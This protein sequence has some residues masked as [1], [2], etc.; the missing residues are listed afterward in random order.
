M[1]RP[2]QRL[3]RILACAAVPV[4][5][6]AAGC[7]SDSDD[8]ASA[9]KSGKQSP[10]PSAS[11]GAKSG[12]ATVKEE[13]TPEAKFAKLPEACKALSKKTVEDLVPAAKDK[14]GT[15]GASDEVSTRGTCSW[16]GLKSNGVDGSQYRWL[17]VSLVRFDS[18]P[19]LGT[20]E[21]RATSYQEKQLRS[22]Q[23][24]EGATGL[25][26]SSVAGV[27]DS[28]T[29]VRYDL[30]KKEG[31]FKQQTVLARTANAVI[32]V[33]Y[34]GAGLAGDKAPD[35][36]KL[37]KDAENAAKEVAASIAAANG[38]GSGSTGSG[39]GSAKGGASA[40]PSGKAG[41]KPDDK[42]GGSGSGDSKG[43]DSKG[44]DDK[45][46]DKP[47]AKPSDEKSSGTTSGGGPDEGKP[48]ASASA[49]SAE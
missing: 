6:V 32:T 15:P 25:K 38:A 45:S 19:T 3:S 46:G 21:K 16:N 17:S 29:A 33:D 39:E 48:S 4:I 1:H 30:K 42:S 44:D 5:F 20:G 13:R 7:S 41:D 47:G 23:A 26:T 14:S 36:D 35:A 22:T 28:A 10:S 40:S 27:G 12:G 24:T 2:V 37:L 43:G 9:S 11:A 18:D 49:A 8:S 34:N 31:S